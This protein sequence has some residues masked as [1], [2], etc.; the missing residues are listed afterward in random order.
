M[1]DWILRKRSD[2]HGGS[3]VSVSH[4]HGATISSNHD[5]QKDV[6]LLQCGTCHDGHRLTRFVYACLKNGR[7]N[8][9]NQSAHMKTDRYKQKQRARAK[10][11]VERRIGD[12]IIEI[13]RHKQNREKV[14]ER[15]MTPR[16][17]GKK[18]Q[19][20]AARKAIE[21]EAKARLHLLLAG[22]KVAAAADLTKG[23]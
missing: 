4:C 13:F 2:R 17:P 20:T 10:Q 15:P 3:R 9:S 23:V 16:P 12:Q 8:L 21:A 6:I 22:K 18:A 5:P 7:H 14:R 1:T 11:D 19:A